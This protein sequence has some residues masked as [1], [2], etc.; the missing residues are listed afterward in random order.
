MESG[1]VE[2][3]YNNTQWRYIC[4]HSWNIRDA[5]VVCRQ[6]GYN[7]ALNATKTSVLFSS[8]EEAVEG[9]DV[10]LHFTLVGCVGDERNIGH[11]K[12][13]LYFHFYCFSQKGRVTDIQKRGE[14]RTCR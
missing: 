14:S 6:L 8:S 10:P 3:L 11:C 4:D 13:K 9:S 7:R 1:N 5:K 12:V 2:V